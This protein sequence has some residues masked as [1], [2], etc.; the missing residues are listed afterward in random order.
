MQLHACG[1]KILKLVASPPD[2][3]AGGHD[4]HDHAWLHSER[5]REVDEGRP[6]PALHLHVAYLIYE[7]VKSF[8][9]GLS[10]S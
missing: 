2:V 4:G 8:R 6:L 3:S 9:K 5:L 10:Q 7:C 1:H